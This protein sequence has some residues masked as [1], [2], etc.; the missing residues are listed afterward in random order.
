MRYCRFSYAVGIS[1]LLIAGLLLSAGASAAGQQVLDGTKSNAATFKVL[2]TFAGYPTDAGPAGC[3]RGVFDSSG[4]FYSATDSGG[5]NGRGAVFELSPTKSGGWTETVIY[6]FGPEYS[7][8]GQFPCGALL[9]DQGGNLYGTTQEGGLYNNGTVYELSLAAGGNWTETILYSF[10]W[11][12]SGDGADPTSGVTMDAD[13]NLYGVTSCGGKGSATSSCALS[14][15]DSAGAGTVYELSRTSGGD[16]TETVLYS[17]SRVGKS[18]NQPGGEV[19]ISGG[20]L[21]GTAAFS[22]SGYGTVWEL[23]PSSSGKKW[24]EKTLYSFTGGLDGA[25]PN[26]H[27]AIVADSAGN[28][29]GI[30]EIGGFNDTG[31][32]WKLVYS[33]ETK[34][35]SEQTLYSFGVAGG[36]DGNSPQWGL[37]LATNATLYGNSTAGG[38]AGVGDPNAGTIFTLTQGENGEWQE[39]TLYSAASATMG[40]VGDNGL[41][42]NASGTLFGMAA[43][44][45]SSG[46]FP[47]GT[48]FELTP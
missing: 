13:G 10:G 4:N 20:N 41:T 22:A 46:D 30:T 16:W 45:S 31:T 34:T 44:D 6:S 29:Y 36:N 15:T 35:Y 23:Q 27:G 38:G 12:G 33:A 11:P 7:G 32:V 19:L 9:I 24:T 42:T 28:L 40:S 39:T 5:V 1:A 8:D 3:N 25:Y 37:I 2:W 47:Y 48:V 21:F 14:G 18:G 17:F 26:L 43:N